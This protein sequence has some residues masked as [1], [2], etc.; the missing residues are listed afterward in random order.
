VKY[1]GKTKKAPYTAIVGKGITFDSGGINL[2][3]SRSIETMRSDMSAAAAV[4]GILNNAI[5]L[6]IRK[7]ILF[8]CALAENAISK[9][10]Y[11]PGDVLKSYSG[12]TVEIGNTDAEGRLVLADA[13]SYVIKNHQPET[14]IDL[15]TLTGACIVALGYDYSGLLTTNDRL[16][17]QLEK[18]AK[19]TD[20]RIWRL[21]LYDEIKKVMKSKIADISNISN[22][23][24]AGTITGAEFIHQFT[25]KTTWAHLDIAGTSFVE[26][27][28]RMYFSHGGTGAGVRLLTHYLMNN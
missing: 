13:I 27:N 24:G 21:P 11:K 19:E 22:Q 9:D 23:K 3:P 2:K 6:N 7:N 5:S 8:V 25:E 20:D 15:A 18:S 16:A 4:V 1:T 12:K 17:K 10:S 14:I 28:S 26:G